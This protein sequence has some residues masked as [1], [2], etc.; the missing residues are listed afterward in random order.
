MKHYFIVNPIAGGVDSTT[1]ITNKAKEIFKDEPGDYEIIV[2]KKTNDATENVERL[3]K[4]NEAKKEPDDL[5]FYACG[6]DG[7]CFEVLNG[8]VNHQHALFSIVP[9]G[10]CNDFLKSFPG[11]DFND[12]NKIVHGIE[13][14][15]D[16]LK[17]NEYYSLN[18][19][20]I[21]FDADVNYDCVKNRAKY[22]TVKESYNAAIIKNLL[23]PIGTKVKVICDNKDYFE[24]KVLLMSYANGGYYGGSF[25]CAPYFKCDDGLLDVGI[26]KKV[27]RLTFAKLL[28][29]Y[30]IG[31]HYE[32]KGA[33]KIMM[34]CYAK[35]VKVLA[36]KPL[37]V[38][39]DGESF[40]WQEINIDIVPRA[41]RFVFPKM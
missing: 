9:V 37:I 16:I 13:K 3:C 29:Y 11:Y 18:V 24:G 7:T 20:N 38:T 8:L 31:T 25:H 28:K 23:K 10:S 27:S 2:T 19:C 41:I 33:D 39:I 22:K 34:H 4:E 14:Q 30:K 32:Q 15:I 26:I 17:V 12:I 21:G 40:F 6:G 5:M 36:E 35:K 1:D